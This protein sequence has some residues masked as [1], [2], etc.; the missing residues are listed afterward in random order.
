MTYGIWAM[1]TWKFKLSSGTILH[2]LVFSLQTSHLPPWRSFDSLFY[3]YIHMRLLFMWCHYNLYAMSLSYFFS[4]WS[5]IQCRI[6]IQTL[7][8]KTMLYLPITL[9]QDILCFNNN[10]WGIL[11]RITCSF[12]F[13][14][15]VLLILSACVKKNVS[16][17]FFSANSL[18]LIF[19]TKRI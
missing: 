19:F 17:F 18:I 7:F 2:E 4:L 11:M 16:F 13:N 5:F 8:K 6:H 3:I 14:L 1:H 9:F 15:F 10:A 12:H